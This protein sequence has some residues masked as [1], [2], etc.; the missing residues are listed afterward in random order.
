MYFLI[1]DKLNKMWSVLKMSKVIFL[2]IDGV[3]NT[4]SSFDKIDARYEQYEND[5]TP[6]KP[7]WVDI[8]MDYQYQV[9]E[10]E[11]MNILNEIIQ[12]TNA[13]VVIS[14]SWRKSLKDPVKWTEK[15]KFYG[16]NIPVIDITGSC[17]TG[18]R[19]TEIHDWLKDH[20]EVTNIIIID[21]DSDM[22]PYMDYH[23]HTDF[24]NGL[25]RTHKQKV[26]DILNKDLRR[27]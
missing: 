9:F 24:D 5:T 14:S 20:P 21:D 26:L 6:N 11:A 23:V 2:D 19:G 27:P 12:E 25:T 13:Q 1:Q 3:I 18:Y 16:C 15:F 22:E 7:T 8:F 10:Q 17:S 4:V